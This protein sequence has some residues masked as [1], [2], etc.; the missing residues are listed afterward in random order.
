MR[1]PPTPPRWTP[2]LLAGLLLAPGAAAGDSHPFGARDLV[3]MS[4]ISDPRVSPDGGRVAYVLRTTDLAADKGSTD[5]WLAGLDGGEPSRL[6]THEAADS[7]PRWAP[8]GESLYFLSTRS[9]SSQVWRLPLAG[10]EA[11]QVTDFALD[12]A[13]LVVSPGGG[14]LAFSADVFPDCPDLACTAKRLAE[15]GESKATGVLY[16]RLFVRH[17]DTWK[18]GRRSHLFVAPAGGGPPVDLTAGLDADVPSKPFGGPEEIAFTPDGESVV[19]AAR[20][21]P[22][23]EPWSTDFNLWVAP[24]DGGA[25]PRRLT[26]NPAWDTHP[27]FSPDGRT[28][29]Y[30]AME[31]AGFEA[32]RFR[33]VLRGWPEGPERVL[34]EAWD[35]S[36]GDFF[37]SPGG[38][39]LYVAAQDLGEEKIFAVDVATGEVEVR[40]GQGRVAS[41]ALAGD[42]LVFALA[43]LDRPAD[44]Y[45]APAGEPA[46]ERTLRRLTD[47]NRERLEEIR[48][49]RFEQFSFPG[50]NGET[51]YG[52]L[53]EP[54]DFAPGKTYP[55]AFL[56]HGGPQGSWLNEFHYRWNPQ[57][58]A[59]AGYGVVLID[60]HGS[61]GY[62]QAFTDSISGDWGGKPLEDL[63]KGFAAALERYPWLDGER[64]CALGASYGG[65]MI[66]WIA[67]NWQ[68]FKCLVNHDGTFDTRSMY[69]T[70]EELW[71]PEWEFGGTPFAD[72]EAYERF[73]PARLV[74]RWQTPMLVVHGQLDYRLVVTQGIQTFTALQRRGI[75]SEFLYFPDEN[76]WVLRPNNSLQ[77]HE[78]VLAW[79]AKWVGTP[80]TIDRGE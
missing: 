24:I 66:N 80:S 32:D 62:G 5:L 53:V 75:P 77:W 16:D 54:V 72:P 56:V 79:L 63:Q 29:A 73:N 1:A 68:A 15:K 25:P 36:A 51:V 21:A 70:T 45:T 71:F 61:T 28:L 18:D 9:G 13:N 57:V 48:F 19:F 40:V 34:T 41:P 49:G 43:R 33:I 78:T 14:H 8:G 39:T 31:R 23:A 58:Y 74:E 3:R 50:W 69:Y 12:V 47:V 55:L 65:Y 4:R 30:A 52:W 26:D 6:T 60:F 59:G 42:R 7:S 46:T 10:G 27:V 37:F 20:V 35:R 11:R 67:G 17:W 22:A 76:H 64:A 2:A 38:E 44:L